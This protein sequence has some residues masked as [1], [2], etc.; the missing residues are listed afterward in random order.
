MAVKIEPRQLPL[1]VL[2]RE[3]G[4]NAV[5]DATSRGLVRAG[6]GVFTKVDEGLS[7]WEKADQL[8]MAHAV[9]VARAGSVV[10]SHR[11]AALIHGLWLL[12]DDDRVHTSQ[13][14]KPKRA[15]AG[16]RRHTRI[17]AA[18]EITEVNGLR[19]T[20][21]ER[22]IIDCA[23]SMH[24]R[25]ALVVAD[26]GMRALVRP[27]RDSP[28]RTA[29]ESE[30]LRARLLT[31]AEEGDRRNLR[32]ARAVLAYADPRSESPFETVVRWIG[33][34]RGLPKPTLQPRYVIDGY[35]H[36]PDL[37]WR[38]HVVKDGKVVR[39][40][41]LLCE[42]D[43]K[44]KYIPGATDGTGADRELSER[45]MAERRRQNRLTSLPDTFM[46]RFDSSDLA[47]EGAIFQRLCSRF[48]PSWVAGLRPVPEL[49][50]P[51]RH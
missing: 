21:I 8:A 5:R 40:I 12:D 44:V 19:T 25:D 33:V 15:V 28:N 50:D 10:F 6:R 42:Y 2:S 45:V 46:E 24:P 9:G 49:L 48:L 35:E 51:P 7:R 17:L 31:L 36:Y 3:L 30:K 11:T 1:V 4:T 13:V 32:Q 23:K 27:R 16:R 29:R 38:L 41:T 37:R 47:D 22:T 26:S 39:T 43:G 20:T 18:E 14:K 34:S